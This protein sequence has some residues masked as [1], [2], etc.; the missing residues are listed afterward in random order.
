MPSFISG[1]DES[2]SFKIS[3]DIAQKYKQLLEGEKEYVVKELLDVRES[4]NGELE[5]LTK[6]EGYTDRHNTWERKETFNGNLSEFEM[7]S[8]SMMQVIQTGKHDLDSYLRG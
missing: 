5:F 7:F 4:D 8:L 1:G 2:C 3:E 6:W